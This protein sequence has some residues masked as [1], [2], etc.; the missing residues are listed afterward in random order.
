MLLKYRLPRKSVKTHD[1]VIANYIELLIETSTSADDEALISIIPGYF[2]FTVNK[3]GTFPLRL[4]FL[5]LFKE[6]KSRTKK[7]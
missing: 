7:L 3:E 6:S 1:L 4:K 5:L 2:R